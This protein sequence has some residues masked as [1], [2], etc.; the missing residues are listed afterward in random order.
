[1]KITEFPNNLRK[2][3]FFSYKKLKAKHKN[4]GE[5][6]KKDFLSPYLYL[7]IMQEKSK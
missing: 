6:V 3:N 2:N 7:T 5:D 4:T 1:M